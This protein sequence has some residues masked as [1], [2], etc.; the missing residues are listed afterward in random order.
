[1]MLPPSLHPPPTAPPCNEYPLTQTCFYNGGSFT[2]GG[3]N[4]SFLR[5]TA[6][7]G[8]RG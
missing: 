6:G 8:G 2:G 4:M 1:M 7:I 5:P 3:G